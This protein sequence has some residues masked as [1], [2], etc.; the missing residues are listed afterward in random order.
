MADLY[1]LP[2]EGKGDRLRGMRWLL[3][4]EQSFL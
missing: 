4:G 1:G 3:R 2:L